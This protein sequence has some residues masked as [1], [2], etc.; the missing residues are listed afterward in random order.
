MD[1]YEVVGQVREL[2]QRQG[3]VSYRALKRQFALDDEYIEDLKEELIAAQRLAADEDGRIL[4]WR[5]ATEEPRSSE[6]EEAERR[7]LT[8]MFCDLVDS[9]SLS[10]QLDPED[11]RE[12]IRAYQAACTEVITQYEG[13][14][15]QLLGDGLLVYFGY[16]VA[17]E[18]DAQRSVHAGL[19]M[20][21]AIETLNRRL[22]QDR[23]ISLAVRLGIHTGP[24]VVGKMGGKGRSEQLA[25]G[26]TPNI[27]SRIQG[28][29]EPDTLMISETTWRLV[30]G[31][32]DTEP[33]GEYDLR[34]VSQPIVVYRVL[35]ASGVQSRLDVASMRGLTPLVGRA[36]EVH[37]LLERWRQAQAG[38][39]QVVLLSGEPGLGK[40]RL[41]QTL[42]DHL[43]HVSH[44]RLECRSSPYYQHSAFYPI[45]DLMRRLLQWDHDHAP[46]EKLRK[47]EHVLSRYR[48]P[49]A[50]TVPLGS[51]LLSLPLA[52]TPYSPLQLTPQRQ[53]QRTLESIVTIL[54]EEAE[55][56]PVLFILEDLHWTDHSTLELLALLID[57]MPGACVFV[58]LTCR[59]EFHPRWG[60]SSSVITPIPLKRLQ[61]DD[62][63]RM[64]YQMTEGRALP[65]EVLAQ[66]VEKTDGVPLYVEE[67][68]KAVLESGLLKEV[69]EHYELRD[70]L[71][72]LAI[73]PTLQDSLMARLDRLTTA[74]AVVQQAAV[75]GRQFSYPLLQSVS[76]L[77]EVTLQQELTR[78]LEAGLIYQH[79][80]LPEATYIFK[81]ALIQD[82]AY[83]SLLRS[84]RQQYHAHIAEVLETQ[85]PDTIATQPEL[86]AQH[87]TEAG[88]IE[89]AIDYW[90][91]AGEYA[92]KRSANAEAVSHLQT[93]QALLQ[94][95]P[96][97]PQR[98]HQELMLCLNLAIALVALQ[99]QSAAE[100]ER[101]FRR[102]RDLCQQ[103]GETPQLLPV[104]WG[105]F[106]LYFA[107][108][109]FGIAHE[110]AE[111]ILHLA[112]SGQEPALLLEAQRGLGV[113]LFCLG[114]LSSARDR[115]QQSI[116]LY[117]PQLHQ[118]HAVLYGQDPSVVCRSYLSFT[119]WLLGYP[120]QALTLIYE[121]LRYARALSHPHTLAFALI[122]T[123]YLHQLRRE[124]QPARA[125]AEAAISLSS[126]QGFVLYG[127]Y[128]M[129]LCGWEQGIQ[130]EGEAGIARLRQ[131][132]AAYRA[133]G[134]EVMRSYFLCMLAEV[135]AQ[136]G[137]TAAGLD[138]LAEVRSVVETTGERFYE[139]E[140]YR[141]QGALLLQESADHH[142]AAATCFQHA[143]AI[144]RRQHARTLELRAATG[145][146]RLWQGQ[147][148]YQEASDVL[149]PVCTWFTEGLDTLD[150]Q[151]ARAVLGELVDRTC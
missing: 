109:A 55:H 94:R 92:V 114:D 40:S 14:I 11:L 126:D 19:G 48:L 84:R 52:V 71:S 129:I 13:N 91:Q 1:F 85:F 53:R 30:Q 147:G 115:L 86:L 47:L 142:T 108:S 107:R 6:A 34:G 24:V 39:G 27:S 90:Q 125:H 127:T 89:K 36:S 141:L 131:S 62:V 78:L 22:Q 113:T 118:S 101:V 50:E 100:V 102:A 98:A 37:L 139:A 136:M 64:V 31:F 26:E 58:L 82:I 35:G 122:A 138:V 112:T 33:L 140:S 25:L 65:G 149:A 80:V 51:T 88:L 150:L 61:D 121:A 124:P 148:K 63:K 143:L 2:L 60:D 9:T 103:V 87:C 3:R 76:G 137:Q 18:D 97:T 74:K 146:A 133:I 117:D 70:A 10:G 67:M 95:L 44:T 81:H 38:M 119:L 132:L 21:K 45:I 106:R 151:E 144:S 111:Q 42:K 116:A 59:P 120:D 28:L 96:A 16:P 99:G 5:G 68:T 128:G 41:V 72:S 12:V 79:G 83:A 20:I 93:G 43:V 7:Q 46:E 110:F 69:D 54:L 75:I 134:S 130:G 123:A 4:V 104:L 73:P 56:Q 77:N 8:V 66:L 29:A 135:H 145:L 23:N 105:L 15:A 57:Q 32:F 49:L 17:H